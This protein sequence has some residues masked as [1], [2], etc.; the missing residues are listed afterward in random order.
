MKKNDAPEHL[1]ETPDELKDF[2]EDYNIM[3]NLSVPILSG[4]MGSWYMFKSKEGF[5]LAMA[6]DIEKMEKFRKY[7]LSAKEVPPLWGLL[8]GSIR[9]KGVNE[10]ALLLGIVRCLFPGRL[11]TYK[12]KKGKWREL[13]F[14]TLL[15]FVIDNLDKLTEYSSPISN[16]DL[17]ER[18]SHRIESAIEEEDDEEG[19]LCDEEVKH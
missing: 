10:H 19:E 12:D 17:E 2:L 14:D 9:T 13:N 16:E 6:D 5:Q 4:Q 3:M 11:F 1:D 8:E 7:C 18:L 15:E